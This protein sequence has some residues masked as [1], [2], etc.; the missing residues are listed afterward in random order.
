MVLS[1]APFLKEKEIQI[2]KIF[3]I[4]HYKKNIIIELLMDM[5]PKIIR[6]MSFQNPKPK[7]RVLITNNYT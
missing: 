6:K 5:E 2:R 3:W 7:F 4:V 1:L